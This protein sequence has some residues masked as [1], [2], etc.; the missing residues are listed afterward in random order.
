MSEQIIIKMPGLILVPATFALTDAEM[1]DLQSFGELLS[2]AAGR[3]TVPD[4]WPPESL[5]DALFW[6]KDQLRIY[7]ERAGWYTW[8]GILQNEGGLVL[9]GGAGFK[10][11]PD[12]AGVVD[13]GYSVLPQFQ[14]KGVACRMV[15]ALVN[16]AFSQSGVKRIVAET[17]SDN[18][19]SLRVLEKNGFILSEESRQFSIWKFYKDNEPF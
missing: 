14:R 3:V 5:I 12:D 8:Y 2:N 16:W 19:P 18:T 7:P 17:F 13:M 6:F 1:K 4:N 15:S 9:A 11:I 10:G